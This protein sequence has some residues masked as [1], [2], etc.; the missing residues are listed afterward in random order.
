MLN[1]ISCRNIKRSSWYCAGSFFT[2]RGSM[3]YNGRKR[4]KK[5]RTPPLLGVARLQVRLCSRTLL[6]RLLVHWGRPQHSVIIEVCA[7]KMIG[8]A[9]NINYFYPRLRIRN[10]K[11]NYYGK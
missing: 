10:L 8:K 11:E 5:V 6:F 7:A 9:P 3:G 1:D 4:S 2:I